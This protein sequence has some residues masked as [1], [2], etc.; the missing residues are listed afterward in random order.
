[1]RTEPV[2]TTPNKS[3]LITGGAG[4]IGRLLVSR[5]QAHYAL[6][7]FD[8]QAVPGIPS[9]VGNLTDFPAVMQACQGQDI[10]VHLAAD[11][12]VGSP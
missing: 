6:I 11:V 7:S 8:L 1:M 3:V 10:V 4:L 12:R 5:L 9:I 2:M